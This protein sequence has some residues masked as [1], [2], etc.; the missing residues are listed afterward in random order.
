M[1]FKHFFAAALCIFISYHTFSTPSKFRLV[2]M[3]D[4]STE[5]T[6]IFD[7]SFNGNYTTETNPKIYYGTNYN[8]VNNLTSTI[9]QPASVNTN[10]QM[11]NNIC[12]LQ[13][14]IPNT[15]YYFKVVDSKGSSIVY[16]FETLPNDNSPLSIIAGGCSR[17][18]RSVRVNANKTVAKLKPHAVLFTGDHTDTGSPQEW[19]WWFEDW[20][21]TIDNNKRITPIIPARG[22]HEVNDKF[23]VELFGTPANV[24]YTSTNGSL[25]TVITLNSEKAVNAYGAQTVWLKNELPQINTTYKI[26]KFH[27]P[28]RPHIKSKLEG[29]TQYAYWAELLED[30]QVD[31]VIDSDSHTSKITWPVVICTGGFNCDEGFKR[32]DKNGVVYAGEGGWGGPLR[33]DDDTKIW[34]RTSGMYNQFKHLIINEDGIE[35]RTVLV[36]TESQVTEVD[37]NNRFNLPPNQ[38]I[39]TTGEVVFI[40]NKNNNTLPEAC[41]IYPTDNTV[42]YNQNPIL[43]QA[44]A[45]DSNGSIQKVS[46][47]INGNLIQEDF[48]YPYEYNFYPFAYGQYQIS[49]IATDNDGLTSCMDMAAIRLMNSTNFTYSSKINTTTDDAEEYSNGY[50]DL[51]NWDI[52]L[53]YNGYTCGF[54][55][56][57]VNIPPNATITQAY[58]QFTADEVKNNTTSLTIF[59]EKN[60][61]ARTFFTNSN[62]ISNRPKTN[63]RVDWFAAPWTQVG[64]NGSAQSTPNLKNIMQEII[65]LNDYTFESPFAFIIEGSGYR[66][67]ETFDGD[68]INAPVLHYSYTIEEACT[69]VPAIIFINVA[70]GTDTVVKAIKEISVNNGVEL[71]EEYTTE[72]LIEDCNAN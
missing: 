7:T 70:F 40:K 43:L 12:R 66:V 50:M 44:N 59:G 28:M 25:L 69:D 71:T 67:S 15:T 45:T 29:V 54:R 16:N 42:L 38:N 60:A 23:L 68:S 30:Y 56:Q 4:L 32:D 10:S 6:L 39:W 37:I 24:Y 51:L 5:M 21:Y 14:L 17:S 20:Q 22:S 27:R 26:A 53:G 46:F 57:N 61:Q 18:N 49:I 36:D 62:D 58:I 8:T 35:L 72:L 52:D 41:L 2:G 48:T 47:Y 19:Q 34:T 1:L 64:A 63:N 11:R 3:G 9:I 55:F 31:L 13:N 33:A 65:D